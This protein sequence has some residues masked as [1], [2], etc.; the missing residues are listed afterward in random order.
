MR[1]QS[2]MTGRMAVTDTLD[3][4][5]KTAI[6]QGNYKT[7][8]DV[9]GSHTGIV[10]GQSVWIVRAFLPGA[11]SASV[12]LE[13]RTRSHGRINTDVLP[14]QMIHPAGLFSMIVLSAEPYPYVLDVQRQ[15]GEIERVADPYSF[16]P[17]LSDYD[18]HL[19]GEGT[20]LELY[21]R[22]GAHPCEVRGV[23]GISF[24]VWAPNARR[25]SVVGDFNNW[26]ERAYP[27]RLHPNGV[28]EIFLPNLPLGTLY[29]FAILSAAGDYR[30]LKSD[31]FA[32]AAELRPGTASKVWDLE[33][34]QWGD[35]E[36]EEKRT[37]HNAETAAISVYELHVGS[38]KHPSASDTTQVTY[39]DL[40]HQLVPYIKDLGYTHVELLPVAEH[41]FDGSWGYQV[42]GYYTPTSRYGTPQDFMYFVDQCHQHGIGVLLDWVPAHFPKDEHGLRYFDGSHLYEHA[43]PR[44]G[45]HPEWGTQV[46]NFGR[47]E[48]RNF[49]TANALFWFDAY[50]IDGLRVDAVASMLYLDYSRTDGEWL[51]NRY[52]G[53]ENL[54]AIAFLRECNENV[55]ARYPHVLMIAEESTAWPKV[56]APVAEGGLGFSLKWNMGWMHDIL[57]YMRYDPVHRSHHHNELTFSFAYAH[58]EKF[59]LALSHDEVVHIKGSMLNKMP[60]DLW[61]KF[62]NLR[63]LYAF[64]YAHPGKKLL[65]MGGEMGQWSEWNFAGFLDWFVLE[66]E[67]QNGMYHRKLR[68][69]VRDLNTLL[70]TEVALHE[71]D[72][73][74][75]GFEWIDGSDTQNS[76]IAFVRY[77]YEKADP[78]L[79]VCNFTPVPRP[80]YRIGAPVAGRYMEVLNSDGE[81]YGGSNVI[82]ASLKTE[83]VAQHGQKQ[84]LV[85]TLPPLGVLALKPAK[86]VKSATRAN[87][88]VS[89]KNS[90]VVMPDDA[91]DEK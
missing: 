87:K 30:V 85:L 78:L 37:E 1:K 26:D 41:P 27:M 20:H 8:F 34:Y 67:T 14:M 6:A 22:L 2:H 77:G 42:T 47:N 61:Q 66:E 31:P 25:V 75:E 91:V 86:P 4:N 9:L 76:V 45:E 35:A 43:D 17:I 64:M 5:T 82:N 51:P 60:G 21:K 70:R 54:E 32:F 12:V 57:E 23:R 55:R 18:L 65:F 24:A 36:W 3:W 58:S 56:T 33:G 73:L 10:Q 28:W 13:A 40:A 7:P 29:K 68:D 46:F 19:I 52:G 53:R 71:C 49:L 89:K 72:F 16:P 84:S 48:V 81:R 38:W 62:A 88:H 74:P 63:V 11:L 79:F 59:I 15:V 50:H 90:V 80:N 69:F 39:R 44:R 83:R